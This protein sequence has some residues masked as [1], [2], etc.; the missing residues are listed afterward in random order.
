MS[1]AERQA[2]RTARGE[3]LVDAWMIRAT[4]RL[5][6][7]KVRSQDLVAVAGFLKANQ[8]VVEPSKAGKEDALDRLQRQR[9]E[10]AADEQRRLKNIER[11]KAKREAAATAFYAKQAGEPLSPPRLNAGPAGDFG[12]MEG[13]LS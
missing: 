13:E 2:A 12:I 3:M 1:P 11:E 6:S 9:K 10:Q 4:E 7:D 5:M 8:F